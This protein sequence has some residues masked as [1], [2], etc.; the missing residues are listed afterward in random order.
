MAIML[1]VL[2]CV[3]GPIAAS[4]RGEPTELLPQGDFRADADG[5]PAGWS[6]DGWLR[7]YVSLLGEADDAF[8]RITTDRGN[9]D[10]T[11]WARDIPLPR[12]ATT[13]TASYL[14]R[15]VEL[16]RGSAGYQ[17][18]AV[19][20]QFLEAGEKVGQFRLHLHENTP[21]WSFEQATQSIPEGADA[22]T[23]RIGFWRA[24]GAFDVHDLRI[25]ASPPLHETP[26][27]PAGHEAP[28]AWQAPESV[29]PFNGSFAEADA[30]EATGWTESPG[31][32]GEDR[33]PAHQLVDTGDGR[34]LE[35]DIPSQSFLQL[36]RDLPAQ[37]GKVYR[38][39]LDARC[40]GQVEQ[41][42]VNRFLD[43]RKRLRLPLHRQ[44]SPYVVQARAQRDGR[45]D[46]VMELNGVG[47]F[48]VREFRIEEL[49]D[50]ALATPTEPPR[51]ELLRN[52]DFAL[53]HLDWTLRHNERDR[54][55]MSPIS[56]T[57]AVADALEA[58]AGQGLQL[59]GEPFHLLFS[60]VPLR[61]DYGR[62][63][64]ITIRG[65]FAPGDLDVFLV[66]PGQWTH[67]NERF[68]P[69]FSGGSATFTYRP[70]PDAQMV[71]GSSQSFALMLRHNGESPGLLR[72]VSL[73]ELGSDDTQ[74]KPRLGLDLV[75][76]KGHPDGIRFVGEPVVARVRW[77]DLSN[78]QPV[79]LVVT[80][81]SGSVVSTLPVSLRDTKA[82]GEWTDIAL[83]GLRQG[84]YRVSAERD[85]GE[86]VVVNDDLAVIPRP[87]PDPVGGFLGMQMRHTNYAGHASTLRDI[88]F[89]RVRLYYG[90][91]W[92]VA[93]P[94]AHGP[95]RIPIDEVAALAHGGLE[96]MAILFGTPEWAST[97]PEGTTGWQAFK[98]YPPRDMDDWRAFVAAAVGATRDHVKYY[99]IWNEPNGHFLHKAPDD[100]RSL[101]DIYAELVRTAAPIIKQLDTDGQ[102]V[103][104]STAG[105][106]WFLV[107]TLRQHPDLIDLADAVSYHAYESMYLANRGALGFSHR[108]LR[109]SWLQNY[110]SEVGR[111][112]MPIID[113]E[114]GLH[115]TYDG[116]DGRSVA[117][118]TAKGLVARQAAGFDQFYLFHAAPRLYPGQIDIVN[119]F[120]FADRPLVSVPAF[121]AWD[122]LLGNAEFVETLGDD[123]AGRHVYRYVRDD[124][125][126]V[127]VAWSSE[128]DARGPIEQSHLERPV[129]LDYMARR[130][131]P[132]AGHT[133]VI[134][135]DLRY[136]AEPALLEMLGLILLATPAAAI[137]DYSTYGRITLETPI[138]NVWRTPTSTAKYIHDI[139]AQGGY[140]GTASG[141]FYADLVGASVG[142]K[143]SAHSF[144][145]SNAWG[146][147]LAP[148]APRP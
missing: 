141:E 6:V 127:L 65:D 126:Q 132:D 2:A 7:Q 105:S 92:F 34:V 58:G 146:T 61:L 11:I 86:L 118:L 44:W 40:V 63:Y 60:G 137:A 99:E 120:G 121:A 80:D 67:D 5:M 73:V 41:V 49:D 101:E 53:G 45:L 125:Y 133:V 145:V 18:A 107:R 94:K 39:T 36:T 134:H 79:R 135:D 13:L 136:Y 56:S 66:R 85:D 33:P 74:V 93:Q 142:A 9:N 106:P 22:I 50:F 144:Q 110:L 116:P 20:V 77:A 96:P 62:D 21:A 124:G 113:S 51:G 97:M 143:A 81:E 29:F 131:T 27:P 38:V 47:A 95:I 42:H 48:Q 102:V 59:P 72:S 78:E 115:R 69:T 103:V 19:E 43:H 4:A 25:T 130:V 83:E 54:S 46:F 30:V 12:G 35:I 112:D 138:T 24:S 17:T 37:R 76:E 87:R 111:P 26:D 16:Q 139:H 104:G 75:D 8:L 98:K 123:A 129:G 68:E 117:M 122:R 108:D 100:P 82:T 119:V 88:G 57:Q 90:F 71:S 31:G 14:G 10:K 128:P 70:R 55:P 1:S 114:S 15:V 109:Q 148:S 3:L 64:R 91:E 89:S 84:W 28:L 147:P 52:G 32:L 140:E 23:V